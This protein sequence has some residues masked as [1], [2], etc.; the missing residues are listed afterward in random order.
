VNAAVSGTV[1]QP[2]SVS[3]TSNSLNGGNPLAPGATL[4]VTMGTL[5]MRTPGGYTF[6]ASTSVASPDYNPSNDA[7]SPV[8]L[9][10]NN[11]TV[12][13]TPSA[14]PVCDGTPY[15]LT[16]NASGGTT[17]SNQTF[18]GSNSTSSSIIDG[19]LTGASTS[20][21]FLVR[22]Q[23]SASTVLQVTTNITHPFDGDV[24]IYLVGPSNCGAI[25]L[26]TDNGGGGANYTGTIFI[27]VV[28]LT[29]D[30]QRNSSVHRFL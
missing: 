28:I 12:T 4:N 27:H 13:L 18:P 2:Y 14:T 17:T 29:F 25:E 5:D 26:S 23:L 11:P 8:V 20:I 19:S 22:E 16:A 30:H 10:G 6:N 3:I 21:S 15:N 7:M 24:D 9:T 1:T